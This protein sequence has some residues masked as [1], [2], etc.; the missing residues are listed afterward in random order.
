MKV[1][2][3]IAC[4]LVLLV[5]GCIGDSAGGNGGFLFQNCE[6]DYIVGGPLQKIG[7]METNFNTTCSNMCNDKY[8]ISKYRVDE[9]TDSFSMCYCDINEC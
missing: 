9:K 1:L 6:P 4:I 5:S 2:L 3:V 7:D 8:K